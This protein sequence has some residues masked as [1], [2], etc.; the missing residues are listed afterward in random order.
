M[1]RITLLL[2][3]LTLGLS[4]GAKEKEWILASPDGRL[5]AHIAADELGLG[6]TYDVEYNGDQQHET[7]D[8]VLPHI[9]QTVD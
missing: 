7:F 1:K 8:Y 9:R 3:V 5:V 2:M 4:V 6:L